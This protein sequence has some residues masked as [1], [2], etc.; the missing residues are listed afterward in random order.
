MSYSCFAG[1]TPWKELVAAINPPLQSN[2]DLACI[3]VDDKLPVADGYRV[4]ESLF[5]DSDDLLFETFDKIHGALEELHCTPLAEYNK[6]VSV[7][8]FSDNVK[9]ALTEPF[10]RS[11]GHVRF[12]D[13]VQWF[14]ALRLSLEGVLYLATRDI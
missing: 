10:I 14:H 2:W 9:S 4:A 11:G 13:L 12:G 3:D 8:D 1:P 5:P 7:E 6:M